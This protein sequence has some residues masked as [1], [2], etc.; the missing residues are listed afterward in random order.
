MS[1][2]DSSNISNAHPVIKLMAYQEYALPE[3]SLQLNVREISPWRNAA[4]VLMA[5][6]LTATNLTV[7]YTTH[8]ATPLTNPAVWLQSEDTSGLFSEDGS[9]LAHFIALMDNEMEKHPETVIAADEAQL[10]RI[11]KLV[12]GV[13][14]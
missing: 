10:D 4:T 8:I 13:R 12:A 3:Q 1:T 2:V 9:E 11:A 14:L 7:T 5:G 6:A